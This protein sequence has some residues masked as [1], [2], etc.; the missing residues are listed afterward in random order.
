MSKAK[1]RAP[2]PEREAASQNCMAAGCPLPWTCND[3]TKC[4]TGYSTGLCRYHHGRES[5]RWTHITRL[6]DQNIGLYRHYVKVLKSPA[7]D[8][9]ASPAKYEHADVPLGDCKDSASY[10]RKI[11]GEFRQRVKF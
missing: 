9:H 8:F 3:S 11:E 4:E 10:K 2:E 1:R 6:I 5:N 7:L